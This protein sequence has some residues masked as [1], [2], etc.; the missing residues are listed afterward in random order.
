MHEE[1]QLPHPETPRSGG[2]NNVGFL[3][4]ALI[5]VAAIVVLTTSSLD[6]QIYYLTVSEVE[7][8]FEEMQDT[9][10]RLKGNVVAGSLTLRDGVL[11]EHRFVLEADGSELIVDYSGA[12]PDTFADDAEVIAL[13]RMRDRTHFDAIEVVAKC[14]SR[15]EEEAPT[16]QASVQ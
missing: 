9:E 3:V 4:G 15:Y 10:F 2:F 5:I 6:D 14:P 13:G 7:T 16:A 12:L 11:S 1:Q 8:S